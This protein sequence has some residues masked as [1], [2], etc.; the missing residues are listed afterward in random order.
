MKKTRDYACSKAV[1]HGLLIISTD[2]LT[3]LGLIMRCPPPR[4]LGLYISRPS[5]ARAIFYIKKC[6]ITMYKL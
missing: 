2:Y 6:Y 1:D 5:R 4:L 3:L